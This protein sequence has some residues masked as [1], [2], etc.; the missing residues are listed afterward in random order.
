MNKKIINIILNTLILIFFSFI[1]MFNF[2]WGISKVSGNSM[3]PN[4][5]NNQTIIYSRNVKNIKRNDIVTIHVERKFNNKVFKNDIVKRVIGFE[6]EHLRIQNGNVYVNNKLIKSTYKIYNDNFSKDYEVIPKDK[7]FVL[8]D[9]RNVSEDS[10]IL[11]FISKQEIFGK[12]IMK[13]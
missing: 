1:L 3:S 12:V 4:L 6:N 2:I 9:N 5:V 8:G 7:V 11:G 10:R 13:F